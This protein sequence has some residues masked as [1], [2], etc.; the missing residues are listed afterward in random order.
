MI[1]SMEPVLG[2]LVAYAFLGERWGG[3]GWAGAGVIMAASLLTQVAGAVEDAGPPGGV[4]GVKVGHG[5]ELEPAAAAE[6][7][8]KKD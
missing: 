1:Y 2:A 5:P 8:A 6:G 4:G 3:W 7:G